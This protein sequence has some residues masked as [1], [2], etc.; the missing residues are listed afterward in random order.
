MKLKNH[1]N[2]YAAYEVGT[3]LRSHLGNNSDKD[4]KGVRNDHG[5][6]LNKNKY[7]RFVSE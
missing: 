2:N 6:I 4:T 3:A 5:K 7:Q 1:N